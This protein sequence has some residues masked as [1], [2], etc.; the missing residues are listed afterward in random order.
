MSAVRGTITT[1]CITMFEEKRMNKKTLP[2]FYT[3][4]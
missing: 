1:G 4:A 3:L 2:N